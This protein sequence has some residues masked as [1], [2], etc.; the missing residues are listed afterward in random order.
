MDVDIL[1]YDDL[2]MSGEEQERPLVRMRGSESMEKSYMCFLQLRRDEASERREDRGCVG[3]Y[4][5]YAI[6]I[7]NIFFVVYNTILRDENQTTQ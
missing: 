1:M 2:V 7:S 4:L 3:G 6:L 5:L